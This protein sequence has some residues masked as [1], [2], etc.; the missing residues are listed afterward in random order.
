[1]PVAWTKAW[2]QGRV[3]YLALGHNPE[4][5]QAEIFRTLLCRGAHWAATPPAE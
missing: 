3:Y 4:S 1:M 5:C 2:G